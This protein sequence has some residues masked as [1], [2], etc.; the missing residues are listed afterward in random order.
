MSYALDRKEAEP[1]A[2]RNV[3]LRLAKV[4]ELFE[5]P[6][7]TEVNINHAGSVWV[8]VNGLSEPVDASSLALNEA[9]LAQVI[10]EL[11][12]SQGGDAVASTTDGWVHA[13]MGPFRFS[14]LMHPISVAG[15]SLNIRKQA[16]RIFSIDE[17]V[18]AGVVSH[19]AAQYLKDA[20]ERGA[21]ILVSGSTDSGKT[22]F[23]NALSLLIPREDRVITIEDT[24]E[25]QLAIPN[26]VPWEYR[27]GRD[28]VTASA[29]VTLAMRYSP[30]RIILGE[31]KDKVAAD[32]LEAC[33][34]GHEGCMSTLHAN[35]AGD[36]LARLELLAL[37]AGLDWPL[38]AIRQQI[39][40]VI[41]CVVQLKLVGGKRR[42][43]ELIEMDRTRE[44]ERGST[45]GYRLVANG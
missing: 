13:K 36:A 1:Q 45:Y 22:T 35:S 12:T 15:S 17:Y 14:G 41:H 31:M 44:P 37:R 2:L 7:L 42:L 34:T 26:W 38:E 21:N 40:Q 5:R 24:C 39:S 3:R 4:F 19:H 11:A 18:D 27:G 16:H 30:R 8:R 20:V 25:L 28:G 23:L 33:N 10:R 29:L 9:N 43:V 32:F 6:G